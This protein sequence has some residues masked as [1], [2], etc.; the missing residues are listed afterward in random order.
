MYYET[1]I[2]IEPHI[3]GLLLAAMISDTLNFKS[4]TT[5]NTDVALAQK[6]ALIAEVD[7]DEYAKDIFNVS[8]TL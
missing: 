2:P 3:A 6:L 1:D 7:I 5:T 8:N 4:P